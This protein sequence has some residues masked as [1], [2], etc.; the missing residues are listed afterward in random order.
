MDFTF[1]TNNYV[2]VRLN[3]LGI[4]ILKKE[5]EDLSRKIYSYNG[6]GLGKFNLNLD[7]DGYYKTQ[8]WCLI[9]NFGEF[10]NVCS[11]PPFDTDIIC[12][13]GEPPCKKILPI[14]YV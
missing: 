11:R 6:I 4:S 1:N 12:C 2:K 5:H 13:Q 8:M 7:E 9:E 14:T 10:I 3:E